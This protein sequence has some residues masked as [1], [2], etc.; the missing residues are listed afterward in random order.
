MQL[1]L[2]G[3][4]DPSIPAVSIAFRSGMSASTDFWAA[5]AAGADIGVVAGEMS[6]SLT[7]I[8]LPRFLKDGGR[9]FIDSGAFSEIKTGVSPDFDQVLAIYERLAEGAGWYGYKLDQLY[10]VAPDKVGDQYGTLERLSQYRDRVRKLIDAGCC[11]IV[12]IQRGA[13]AAREMLN[14]VVDI[15]GCDAFMAGIPSNKEALSIEECA[16]LRHDRFH[17]LGRVQ[18]NADQV[19]RLIALAKC[20]PTAIITADANWLRGKIPEI[21]RHTDELRRDRAADRSGIKWAFKS[22]RSVAI[23]NAILSDNAWGKT[24]RVDSASCAKDI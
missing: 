18:Q 23:T 15:V 1:T 6:F 21:C 16:S 8:G 14:R 13:L 20:N 9:L 3:F 10:L 2:D 7:M 5:A 11:V 12:P 4:A 24:K 22:T 19:A 17:I